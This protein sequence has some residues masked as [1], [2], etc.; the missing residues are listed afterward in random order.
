VA[1]PT[2]HGDRLTL[3]EVFLRVRRNLVVERLQIQNFQLLLVDG[4]KCLVRLPFGL[5]DAR[6]KQPGE[7]RDDDDDDQQLNERARSHR[8]SNEP[9]RSRA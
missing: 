5:R 3:H 6:H 8:S 4:A 7:D 1:L 2:L 9:Q